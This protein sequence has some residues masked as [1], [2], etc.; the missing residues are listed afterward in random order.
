MN[1]IAKEF[2][3]QHMEILPRVSEYGQPRVGIALEEVRQKGLTVAADDLRVLKLLLLQP[4][5]TPTVWFHLECSNSSASWIFFI[6]LSMHSY[7]LRIGM[8]L[9]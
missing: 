7:K 9:N 6:A 2:A 1:V 3:R 8:G 4:E 5:P